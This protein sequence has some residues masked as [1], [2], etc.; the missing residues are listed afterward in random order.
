VTI[1]IRTS[2]GGGIVL[3]VA[4][5]L[6]YGHGSGLSG[7]ATVVLV[8]LV[9]LVVLAILGVLGCLVYRAT[10]PPQ[11]GISMPR[12]TLRAEVLPP[13]RQMLAAPVVR[14]PDDQLE[15]LAEIL[16]RAQRPE[17]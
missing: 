1:F 7:T 6:L 12:A 5:A 10:R 2:G 8:A 15:Q 14:L 9:V 13:D 3:L 4:L 11:A 16:R 17:Q